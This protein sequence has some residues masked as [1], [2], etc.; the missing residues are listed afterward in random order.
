MEKRGYALVT[1]G[2]RG[3]GKACAVKLAR[4]G[5]DVGITFRSDR[6]Q[7]EEVKKTIEAL[8]RKCDLLQFDISDSEECAGALKDHFGK[9]APDV[10]VLNAGI[11]RDNLLLWMKKQEWDQ[12]IRTNLDGFYNMVRPL[13]FNML[14]ARKGRIIVIS[15]VSGEQG[16]AGQ[17]NYSASKAG[18][19]G[20]AKALA[21]EVG[22][23]G[24][25]VNVVSPGIIETDMTE[26]MPKEEILPLIPLNRIGR[27][28][29]VASVVGFLAAE[30]EMYIHGQVIGVNGGLR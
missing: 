23:K 2:N 16:Q 19:I 27:P 11:T 15:S 12:V 7:A 8:E 14:K 5:F 6:E 30:E 9:S 17:V 20:A 13:M 29:E 10:L 18:L 1:G 24:I 26:D 3:I 28:E 4:S 25:L 22:K 21:R